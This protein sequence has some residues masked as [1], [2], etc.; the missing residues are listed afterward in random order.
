MESADAIEKIIGKSLYAGTGRGAA[1][2]GVHALDAILELLMAKKVTK[3]TVQLG[4]DI[5]QHGDAGNRVHFSMA[6]TINIGNYE[7]V[8]VE[9]GESVVV[10]DGE[11]FADVREAV[12]QRVAT[13]LSALVEQVKEGMS[14]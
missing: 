11:S 7:S 8:R 2:V 4:D 12:K 5:A 10:Q 13:D 9:Y 3:P 14:S 6:Q 1:M